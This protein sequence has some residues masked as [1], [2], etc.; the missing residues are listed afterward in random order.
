MRPLRNAAISAAIGA[1]IVGVCGEPAAAQE[2]PSKKRGPPP[3]APSLVSQGIRYQAIEPGTRSDLEPN[4][5][6]VAATAMNTGR[7]LWI[8]RIYDHPVD[9]DMEED[10]QTVFISRLASAEHGRALLVIDERGRRFSVDL[11]SQAVHELPKPP[12]G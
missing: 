10:K 3:P 6:Y 4:A 8:A 1:L 11:S 7:Q 9:P 2:A 12:K 5:A